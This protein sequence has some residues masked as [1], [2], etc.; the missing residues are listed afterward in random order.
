[1]RW[2]F[3]PLVGQAKGDGGQV[4]L[5]RGHSLGTSC[6]T[7]FVSGLHKRLPVRLDTDGA[8][9]FETIVSC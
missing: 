8:E 5:L 6:H 3:I 7:I 9:G 2:W 1:M 4:Q